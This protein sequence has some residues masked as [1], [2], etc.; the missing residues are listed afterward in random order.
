MSEEERQA[1]IEKAGEN[2]KIV[3]AGKNV[4]VRADASADADK[5]GSIKAGEEVI[6]TQP[7]Y[8]E[9]WHQILYDGEL[10]YASASYL[11]IK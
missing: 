11:V 5:V 2:A 6:V 7:Y 10:C 3:I 1:L 8:T 9:K 4:N